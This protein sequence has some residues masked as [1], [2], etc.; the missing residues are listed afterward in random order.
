MPNPK[1]LNRSVSEKLKSRFNIGKRLKS[2]SADALIE[3]MKQTAPFDLGDLARMRMMILEEMKDKTFSHYVSQMD[4]FRKA[5]DKVIISDEDILNNNYW[6]DGLCKLP[7]WQ[8]ESPEIH[9]IYNRK[10][11]RGTNGNAISF[12][13]KVISEDYVNQLLGNAYWM[14]EQ[15]KVLFKTMLFTYFKTS[16]RLW[17]VHLNMDFAFFNK[18]NDLNQ[19]LKNEEPKNPTDVAKQIFKSLLS[20]SGSFILKILQQI[21]TNNES[22][23]GGFSVSEIAKDIFTTVPSLSDS[24]RKFVVDAFDIDPSYISSMD[25]KVLGSASIAEA[26]KTFS[27]KYELD[28]VM[29][30]IKPIYA[31]YFLCEINFLLTDAWIAIAKFSRSRKTIIQCRK[32]LMFFIREFIKEFDYTNEFNNTTVGFEVYANNSFARESRI[33]SLVVLECKIDPFPVLILNFVS[34]KSIDALMS[35]PNLSKETLIELYSHVDKVIRLWFKNTLWGNG[36]FHADLHPGNLVLSKDNVLNLI[37]FGS[38]GVLRKD[39]Q[40]AMINAMA[41]SGQFQQIKDKKDL[42]TPEGQLIHQQ[43]LEV[44]KRFVEAIWNVCHVENYSTNHLN[45]IADLI[46][47]ERYGTKYGLYFSGL[48]LDIIEFSDDIGLCTNSSILLFGRAAAYI[49]SLMGAVQSKCDDV[50]VCP[51]WSIDGVIRS[52]LLQ[53]PAQLGRFL[54]G[55]PVC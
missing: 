46:L 4:D 45:E 29:K 31:Y 14:T 17:L 25:P 54:I 2:L 18:M 1:S 41:I 50:G 30:F 40:C 49:A 3:L 47:K 10:R 12:A 28:A 24:E 32:L 15:Q 35:D 27:Q 26:H 8:T 37:D 9:K 20:G 51:V 43:N 13:T 16:E 19:K 7:Y 22:T 6:S 34:G 11:F 55:L 42:E 52:N 39:E 44:S 21:N 38:C 48:F 23:V 36:F 53:N 33:S 5:I